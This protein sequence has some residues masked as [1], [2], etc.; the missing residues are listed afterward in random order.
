MSST[1]GKKAALEIVA[2]LNIFGQKVAEV[3]SD[4]RAYLADGSI[5]DEGKNQFTVACMH[6]V[7]VLSDY[8]VKVLQS[9]M[10]GAGAPIDPPISQAST[11]ADI[12]DLQAYKAN[13]GLL[14]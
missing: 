4:Y 6:D 2:H 11:D 8:L 7:G 13:G 9:T 10:D 3:V 12:I 1:V 5:S 14:N